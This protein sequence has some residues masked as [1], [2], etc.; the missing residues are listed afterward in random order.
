MYVACIASIVP[1]EAHHKRSTVGR[2]NPGLQARVV[3]SQGK[4][5]AIGESGELWLKSPTIMK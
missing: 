4:D 2:M 1:I 3:D 5:V